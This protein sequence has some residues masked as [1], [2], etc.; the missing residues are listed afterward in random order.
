ML[1]TL[2]F[3][4]EKDS[5]KHICDLIILY[6]DTS[7]RNEKNDLTSGFKSYKANFVSQKESFDAM[8]KVFEPASHATD[9]VMNAELSDQIDHKCADN[10]STRR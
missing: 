10:S 8:Q 3:N 7:W 9:E 5:N 4:C 6:T 1:H 2:R